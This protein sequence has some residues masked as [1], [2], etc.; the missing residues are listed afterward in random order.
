LSKAELVT[1]D[2]EFLENYRIPSCKDNFKHF[3]KIM[4][5]MFATLDNTD[6]EL[7]IPGVKE[8]ARSKEKVEE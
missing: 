6:I 8:F 1:L 2:N 5:E 3:S 4:N 7:L